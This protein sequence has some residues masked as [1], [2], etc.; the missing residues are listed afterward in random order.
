MRAIATAP[1]GPMCIIHGHGTGKLK[2]GVQEFL[3]RH[4]QISRFEFADK[5]DRGAGSTV[6]YVK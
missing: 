6:A 4:P 2:R 5:S 1:A 3:K